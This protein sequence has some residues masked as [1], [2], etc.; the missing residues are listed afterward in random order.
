M[1]KYHGR[2]VGRPKGFY[3]RLDHI[4]VYAVTPARITGKETKLPAAADQWPA[5][6]GTKT[7]DAAAPALAG[8]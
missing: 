3:P 6:D 7:P 5:R 4:T 1:A 8:T 2:D